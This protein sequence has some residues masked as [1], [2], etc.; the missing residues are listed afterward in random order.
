MRRNACVFLAASLLATG[1]AAQGREVSVVAESW[2]PSNLAPGGSVAVVT[3]EQIEES[4]AKNAAEALES[5]AGFSSLDYGYP[6][7]VR[8]PS[9]RGAASSQVLVIVDGV[10]RND[11]RSGNVDLADIPAES[12]ERIEVLKGGASSLY[13]ADAVGGV[14]VVTTKH[15]GDPSLEVSAENRAYPAALGSAAEYLVS[16]Q[17]LGVSGQTRLGSASLSGAASF[18]RAGD[19]FPAVEDDGSVL[20]RENSEYLGAAASFGLQS[21]ALGGILAAS[22]SG[23]YAE[24]GT[25]GGVAWLTP[26]ASQGNRDLRGAAAWSSDSIARGAV[27][28]DLSVFG[29][30]SRM[31]YS[32]P[33]TPE[34]SRHD[35]ASAGADIRGR[36]LVNGFLEIPAG[37]E[38]RFDGAES[39]NLGSEYRS[40]F[41]AGAY[42]APVF[43]LG[44]KATVSPS[45]RYDWYDDYS[46]GATYALGASAA[47]SEAVTLKL[48]GGRSYRAPAFNDLY[49]NDPW[50]SGNPNL[51]PETSW[52]AEVGGEAA[53][54][55]VRA[56]FFGYLRYSED[57]IQWVDPDDDW[58]FVPENLSAAAFFG[59]D[60]EVSA[61]FGAFGVAASYS[62]LLS[63][64]LSGGKDLADDVRVANLPVH[65]VKLEPS[66]E[67]GPVKGLLRASWRS[68]RYINE[69]T[70]LDPVFLLGARVTYKA[71]DAVSVY[72]DGENLLNAAYSE[73]N[74]Y[75]MPGVTLTTGVRITLD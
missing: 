43:S 17:R 46:A 53:I 10:R 42:A 70:T 28:L 45:L 60:A 36:F 13:G 32:D 51:K 74:G 23:R 14:I 66:Y 41:H 1:A 55:P 54:G 48:T 49:W 56:G 5:V 65:T 7:S 67:A 30:L 64:D 69:T 3:A 4:G 44:K 50:M 16:G 11:A 63:Y 62:L 8:A 29:V 37:L 73:T 58:V 59:A 25:P 72:L 21:P 57:L 18:E 39:S 15:G 6:G 24:M 40:R 52:Y 35:T 75:P 19:S 22:L 26:R 68:E 9:L 61:R 47:V 31:E 71:A 2:S 27:S 20:A 34:E 33:A 12:I 38:F